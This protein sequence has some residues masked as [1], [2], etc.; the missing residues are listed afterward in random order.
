MVADAGQ[1]TIHR[2]DPAGKLLGHIDG[3]DPAVGDQLGFVLP[4]PHFDVAVSSDG[5]VCVVNPGKR[6]IERY[7]LDGHFA[8]AWGQMG[9]SVEGF[10]GC[11]NPVA[12]AIL[13]DR[14][15]V[16]AEKGIPRVKVYSPEGKFLGVVAGWEVLA[17]NAGSTVETREQ[18][19]LPVLDL[20][21]DSQGR[22]LVLDPGTGKVRIFEPKQE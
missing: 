19:R 12:L 10:C 2:Y 3:H 11:C 16:T 9:E 5:M 1:R 20:A 4:S 18:Y 8:D 6:R 15:F 7:T 13:P 22:V 17:P 21:A 14:R